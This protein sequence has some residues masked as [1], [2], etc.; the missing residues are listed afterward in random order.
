MRT[1]ERPADGARCHQQRRYP[2]NRALAGE[3][4]SRH[5]VV[6]AADEI[7]GDIRRAIIAAIGDRERRD[8]Q[9][10]DTGAEI[11]AV[12]RHR[13]HHRDPDR[14]GMQRCLAFAEGKLAEPGA[15]RLG[16]S[17]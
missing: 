16:I 10:A 14:I 9:D 2:G 6:E 11:A 13:H 7:L 1:R 4:S 3:D 5:Q 12:D 15:Y 8:Q 17:K